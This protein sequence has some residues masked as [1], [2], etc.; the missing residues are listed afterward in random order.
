LRTDGSFTAEQVA[1]DA[2]VSVATIYNRFPDGRDGLLAAAF[3]QSLERVVG[4]SV[5]TL[6]VENL[7]D[8]G[9]DRTMCTL[10][11]ELADVFTDEAL[12]MRVALA[13]LPESR[14]LRDIYR[15]HETIA[16]QAN[17]R[18]I[19]LGQVANRISDGDADELADLLI[20]LGQGV[21]N[22]LV[23]GAADR[24]RLCARLSAVM[25]AALSPMALEV[26]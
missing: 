6:T 7:L 10:V 5:E 20:V 15:R 26:R 1:T 22:P 25:V 9:L 8:N 11:E 12:V 14:L 21:N 4:A 2:G 17:R 18:F 24:R 13:R 16:R 19:E 3:D 23:L